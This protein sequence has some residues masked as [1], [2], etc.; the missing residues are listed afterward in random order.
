MKRLYT[1]V[2]A[3]IVCFTANAVWLENYPVDVTQPD[4]TVLHLFATGDE[5]HH[6]IHDAAGYT[7]VRH[8][9]TG[10]VMYAELQ[11]DSLV[12]SN[13]RYG[14][15]LPRSI[16]LTPNLDVSKQ[17]R[18]EA[19]NRW[20]QNARTDDSESET[21]ARQRAPG[22]QAAPAPTVLRQ[23]LLNNIVIYIK[24]QG[25]AG[26][27]KN[28]SYFDNI[29]N[30]TTTGASLAS[31]Y[32]DISSNRFNI[33]STFYPKITSGTT[34]LYYT[35]Q[36]PRGYYQPY[37]ATTNPNGY[38]EGRTPSESEREQTMVMNAST[39]VQAQVEAAF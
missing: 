27:T 32:R 12:A 9:Q 11:N 34:I 1:L 33:S 24:F 38:G 23:G 30:N 37:N 18:I 17:K 8:P 21:P 20:W 3:V 19:Y 16:V 4:G 2:F 29:Y 7:L 22:Q 28:Q 6:R 39:Y 10:W 35:D 5:Y 31:Y 15:A 26:F 14:Q 25:E 13:I 36:Y